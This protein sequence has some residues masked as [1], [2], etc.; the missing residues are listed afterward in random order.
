[1]T[2]Q[3]WMPWAF[4]VGVLSLFGGMMAWNAHER[5]LGALEA[6]LEIVR[7]SAALF[8]E[9]V[10]V[11][12]LALERARVAQDSLHRMVVQQDAALRAADLALDGA[13]ARLDSLL[14]HVGV[15]WTAADSAAVPQALLDAVRTFEQKADADQRACKANIQ[16]AKNETAG[17]EQRAQAAERE[18]G[19]LRTSLALAEQE[20]RKVRQMSPTKAGI[21][22]AHTLAAAL[23]Y[24]AGWLTHK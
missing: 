3:R 4:V 17:C 16:S 11:D 21:W 6:K 13:R 9:R 23:G 22:T 14:E 12:A 8:R 7:D 19:D 10:R 2:D 18:A 1:M 15:T 24:L 20:T 5:A